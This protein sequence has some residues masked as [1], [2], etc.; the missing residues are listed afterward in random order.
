MPFATL[1]PRP[2]NMLFSPLGQHI[3]VYEPPHGFVIL[4][5]AM[6]DGFA[7]PYNHMLHYNQEMILNARNDWL[8]CKVFSASLQGPALA[9]FHKLSR[10]LRNLFNELWV[11]FISQYRKEEHQLLTNYSQAGRRVYLRLHKEVRASR[12]ASRFL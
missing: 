1:I 7:D 12:L 4:A 3:L 10:N 11:A 9:C 8:L 6:F 2:D 5:F